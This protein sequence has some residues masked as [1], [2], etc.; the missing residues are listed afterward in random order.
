MAAGAAAYQPFFF[1][2]VDR[3]GA[4]SEHVG[5]GRI[6][7]SLHRLARLGLLRHRP[8]PAWAAATGL[9]ILGLMLSAWVTLPSTMSWVPLWQWAPV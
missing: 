4:R 3:S 9:A 5:G 1:G 6:R 2:A 7:A 8:N